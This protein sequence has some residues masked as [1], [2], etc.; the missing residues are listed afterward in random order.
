MATTYIEL[1]IEKITG[2]AD[3]D[4]QFIISAQKYVV[5]AIPKNLMKWA[6]SQSGVMTS[7]GDSDAVLNVDTVLSVKRNGYACKEISSDDLAWAADSN[8]L[9]KATLK[10]PVYAVSGGKIQIQPEPQAGQ[11]GYYYYVDFSKVDDSSDLRNAVIFHAASKEFDRLSSSKILDWSDSI[12]PVA[13]DSPSFGADLSITSSLPVAP[14]IA[15]SVATLTG[16]APSYISPT[17][18]LSVSPTVGALNISSSLPVF[19]SLSDNSISFSASVP[20]YTK[21]VI[22]INAFPSLSWSLPSPPVPPSINANVSSSGGAEVDLSK[23]GTAPSYTPPVMQAPNWSDVENWIL[24]EEDSEMLSARVNAIQSQISEYQAKL[25]ESQSSFNQENIEYQAKLQIAMQDAQQASSGDS[26]VINK[27]SSEVQVYTSEVNNIIQNNNAQVQE[28]QNENSISL[29]KYNIDISN[30]LNKF[31]KEN[32]EY[33]AQL[34]VS[35]ENSRLSSTDDNQKIQKFSSEVSA[36]QAEVEKEVQDY[37]VQ[38]QNEIAVWQTKRQTELQQYA[39]DIQNNLNKFNEQSVVYESTVRKDLQDAQLVD[40]N[41]T[42]KIQRYTS[43][44]QSYQQD[45][46]RIIQEYS[47]SLEKE[48]QE[49]QNK[50]ALYTSEL[51][52]YQTKV[53]EQTQK[54]TSATQNAAYY[55]QESRKYY[56]WAAQEITLYIQNNSRIISTAIA[57]QSQQQA[58]R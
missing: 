15:S 56:D 35:I 1:D 19:P 16:T 29:Q 50:L 54:V 21:P 41:E 40:A 2:V 18:S 49:Y 22:S 31:N 52:K 48:I 44:I 36:Y 3:A 53:T 37:Q 38:L 5:S 9:K 4:D 47:N 51:Q 20:T 28:W 39:S 42:R 25:N 6:S 58:R 12:E 30:E 23:L 32:A 43:E 7:N 10:H 17:V 45:V 34:Q 46:N 8:S 14:S 27:F 11:E 57:S 26:V 33:Q 24:A 13:P 55:S